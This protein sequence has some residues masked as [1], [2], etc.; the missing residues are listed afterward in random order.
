MVI[1]INLYNLHTIYFKSKRDTNV[2]Y[3][4]IKKEMW[5]MFEEVYAKVRGHNVSKV[6]K[7]LHLAIQNPAALCTTRSNVYKNPRSAHTAVSSCSIWDAEQTAVFSYR[8]LPGWIS[9][10]ESVHSA[11]GWQLNL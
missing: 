6:C 9:T 8:A 1:V 7:P 10:S 4:H 3:A 2:V 11:K 5:C